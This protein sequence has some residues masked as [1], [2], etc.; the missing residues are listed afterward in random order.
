MAAFTPENTRAYTSRLVEALSYLHG[1]GVVAASIEDFLHGVQDLFQASGVLWWEY[2]VR[3]R[4]LTLSVLAGSFDPGWEGTRAAYGEGLAGVVFTDGDP[5]ILEGEALRASLPPVIAAHPEVE[6]AV[7]IRVGS[8]DH[9]LGV[10]VILFPA[11]ATMAMQQM[12]TMILLSRALGRAIESRILQD[13]LSEQFRRLLLLHDLS[14]ILQSKRP[15]EM[16]LEKLI[17][18]LS[19]AFSA[20]YGHILLA[21]QDEESGSP[22]L[23]VRA[24]QGAPLAVFREIRLAP[25]EGITGTVF[26]TGLPLLVE[27]VSRHPDYVESRPDTR[28]EMAV[29]I[30]AEGE[31][32]GVLNLESNRVG[33]FHQEDLRLAS[34]VAA[35]AGV[36][37]K[38]ALALDAAVARMRELELV[39]RVTRAI[40]TSEDLEELL[41]RIVEEVHAEMT[42]T[43]VGILLVEENGVDKRG[44]AAAGGDQQMFT[45]LNMRVGKGITGLAADTGRMQYVPDVTRDNR[46]VPV[47]P[48]IRSELAV[49]LMNKGKVIGVLNLESDRVNAFGEEDRR[50]AEIVAAQISQILA[51]AILY[52]ELA[53][54][55]VTDGL[56][57]LFNHRQFF[58]RLE[59]EFKRAI[60]YSYPL[61]LIMIDIDF[62]KNFNDTF[63][64]LRGDEV[65]RRIAHIISGTMR[66]TDVVSR[67]G[68]EEFAVILPLCHE[69]TAAEVAERLRH[70]IEQADLGGDGKPLTISLGICTA[71]QNADSHEELVRRADDAMYV[72]K[73]QGR[74]RSTLWRPDLA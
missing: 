35:Q 49:P 58:I 28:S 69:S 39:N 43:V 6:T 26:Q 17:E 73:R 67:Y 66:E 4:I 44:H 16:R 3:D 41:A 27:D 32:I 1:P 18:T 60:R 50:V 48:T 24:A 55:A 46:Y 52:E 64:H 19:Q 21:G 29:P 8:G 61:S 5:Q 45:D 33:A 71:P 14:S 30:S 59:A 68:G 22:V 2:A 63:G 37:L 54:M 36:T 47:D 40:A 9:P 74:N 70:R 7:G 34:I 12:E 72:S 20:R 11:R 31:V 13:E 15:L 53:L 65:L 23:T 56:T 51:K 62:F 25:G 10:L 38:H 42:T 57:G